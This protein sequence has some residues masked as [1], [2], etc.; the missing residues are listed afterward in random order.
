MPQYDP[1][2]YRNMRAEDTDHE[3]PPAPIPQHDHTIG[4]A[5]GTTTTWTDTTGTVT[6]QDL[7]TVADQPMYYTTST[8]TCVQVDPEQIKQCLREVLAEMMLD[9]ED[10]WQWS[11][12][13]E[14]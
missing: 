5:T 8:S 1:Y 14:A 7:N 3:P 13:K 6:T 2:D 9:K 10:F 11:K 12:R 4:L